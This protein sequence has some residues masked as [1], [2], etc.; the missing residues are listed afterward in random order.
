MNKIAGIILELT[1]WFWIAFVVVAI[2]MI[3]TK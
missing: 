1:A 2:V 3:I